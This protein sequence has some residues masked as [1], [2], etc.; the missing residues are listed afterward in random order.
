MT[1]SVLR[2][3]AVRDSFEQVATVGWPRAFE[4]V[5]KAA[6]VWTNV[7]TRPA[8]Q[9]S[10]SKQIMRQRQQWHQKTSQAFELALARA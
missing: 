6:M 5:F 3:S 1:W 10:L 4:N 9:P 7:H 8:S 2:W